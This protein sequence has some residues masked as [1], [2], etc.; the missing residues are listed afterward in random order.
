LS[1]QISLTSDSVTGHAS[2]MMKTYTWLLSFLGPFRWTVISFILCSLLVTGIEMSIPLFLRHFIDEILPQGEFKPLLWML[3]GISLLLGLMFAVA[4][5]KNRLQVVLQEQ[6][7]RDMQIAMFAKLRQLGFSYYERHP[8][9]ET[10]SLFNTEVTAVQQVYSVYFPRLIGCLAILVVAGGLMVS[11]HVPLTL[12]VIPCLLSYYLVGPYFEKRAA[13]YGRQSQSLRSA[14][15]QR[16]YDSVSGLQELRAAGQQQWDMET[17]MG[18]LDLLQRNQRK[19]YLMAYSRRLVRGLSAQWGSV[20]VFAYGAYLI[21]HDLLSLGAFVAFMFYYYRVM[22]YVTLI[23]TI[24]S[25]QKILLY[26]A[27][28]LH[29][30][31]LETPEV[32]EPAEPQDM[33]A[34]RGEL[35]FE[36]VQFRYAEHSEVMKGFSLHVNAGEKVALVGTSGNGKS[37]L[38]KLIGRFYDP[39]AGR[40]VLDGVPIDRLPLGRLRD[41][42][43]FVFQETYLFGAS[44]KDNIRFGRPD[45]TDEEVEAAARAACAH[46]FIMELPDGYDTFVGERGIRL[47]GGQKQRVA[48]ARMFIKNP[49]IV[50]LDE[51]TSALDNIS[52][53]EVQQA[54]ENLFVGRTTIAVAHRLSTVKNFDRI[55]I[56]GEGRNAEMGTYE[57]L[58]EQK[59]LLYQLALGKEKSV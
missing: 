52:E 59:G 17:T 23:V 42:L 8:T 39:G 30:F 57:E 21:G 22:S 2:S 36:N 49:S 41:S 43:G 9:G 6:T 14:Y 51:A 35:K 28:K 20:A 46:D 29:R 4:V 26:Q 37:T 56:V 55:V 47:S 58:M 45:A 34:I 40:I 24:A 32:D 19:E 31:M 54:L 5:M 18:K 44:V 27:E 11:I 13:L 1:P 48:I 12:I 3:M 38:L 53:G 10:L 16:V 7:A 50:L 33:A 15:N 25:E